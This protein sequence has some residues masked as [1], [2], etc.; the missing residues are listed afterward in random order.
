MHNEKFGEKS[1]PKWIDKQGKTNEF[2]ILNLWLE[3]SRE[4]Q[5]AIDK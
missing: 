5:G 1:D 2:Q 3:Y 4:S